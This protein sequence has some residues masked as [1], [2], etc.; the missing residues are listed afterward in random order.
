[1]KTL[2][3]TLLAAQK[4]PSRLPYVEAKV[5]D[6]EAGIKRLTWTRLYTG[7]E[8]DNHHGIAFD[9]QSSMH[10]IRSG[11]SSTLLYQKIT[12]PGPSSNYSQWTQIATN[13][14]G[15]CAIAASGSKVYIF[16]RKTANVL[17][18][19]YSHDYG[20]SW[21]NA[22]LADYSE[23]VSLA[24]CWWGTGNNV[25]CFALKASYPANLN[26]IVLNTSDQTL[27]Q[28]E[29]CDGNHPLLDTY[30]IGAS[31]NPFWPAIEIVFAGKESDS[32]YNHF[33]LFRTK[34]SDTYHFLALE[35][36][37]MAPDGEDITY[38][39]PDCHLPAVAPGEGG[40]DYETNRIIAV[41][42]FVGTTAYT[43]PLICHMV[44][45]TYWSD[46]TFTEP[47]P[48]LPAVAPGV[49]G[50]RLQS[51]SDY[52][53]MEKP[54]GV[55][56]APR[57]ALPAI[58][59]TSAGLPAEALAQAGDIISLTQRISSPL[60]G[61]GQG[62]GDLI[63]TL[64]NSHGYYNVGAGLVP[65]LV[66]K[67]SEIVLNLGYKTTAGNEAVESDTY[68]ID[69]WEYSSTPNQSL[70]T[71]RCLD[72]WGLMDRWS[73]RYQ[74]RWNK[75]EVN[76][77]SV[78]QILYQLLARVGI[79]LSNDPSKPQSSAIN[80]LYPDFALDSGVG[81]DAAIRRLLSFV[82][83]QL[84]FRGQEAFTKNPLPA[85]AP[86]YSYG[87]GA[88]AHPIIAGKYTDAVTASRTRAIGQDEDSNRIVQDALDWDLLELAIDI[89]EQDYDPNLQ[90]ATRAQERADALLRQ[91]S[92]R[93]ERGNLV[94]PTNVG[95]ELL[96]VIEVTDARCGGSEENYRVQGIRIL[97]DRRKGQ[98]DQ[99]FTLG[100]P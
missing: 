3:A 14:Y 46:T 66:N 31:F 48:F 59:L 12:N 87:V 91:M 64:D 9:S 58:V 76:P 5:Y 4:K 34:F 30:G 39:Y 57:P 56:R 17:W 53:W 70:F 78:W 32:P 23:V 55:W 44:K 25:V 99:M 72:G 22:Q 71:I 79:K 42:K 51:T 73:A 97:Y 7:S 33:D 2:T 1:M 47:K 27:S 94:V 69:S 77:K 16:Y 67:R 63:I 50:L 98:Y 10:R 61:E 60:T 89:L 35:S 49:G 18:K 41:E 62:E 86:S 19:Y 80:N 74:M 40:L 45:G 8:P 36:F 15:P 21:Q 81:G 88:A 65:A 92:L 29:W 75:D 26:G 82:P 37:L 90:T 68:W 13:C 11:G 38:Q 96:D 24:A 95:Q 20:Q 6:Y 84:V 52:W 100:A 54:D 85:E 43:R 83:D 93:A 28:H